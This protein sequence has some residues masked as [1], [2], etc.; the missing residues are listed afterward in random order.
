[1][2]LK[3]KINERRDWV[4]PDWHGDMWADRGANARVHV[5][6]IGIGALPIWAAT[7][8]V[9]SRTRVEASSDKNQQLGPGMGCFDRVAG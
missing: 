3:D 8:F 9:A 7:A 2:R 5:D 6:S 4:G 1:M